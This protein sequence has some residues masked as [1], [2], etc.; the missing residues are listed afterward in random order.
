MLLKAINILKINFNSN[1]KDLL[2]YLS[3]SASGDRYEVGWEV[4]QHFPKSIKKSNNEKYLFDNR[5]EIKLQ[6]LEC[7]VPEQN[8]E[9]S[10]VC[11]ISDFD[12]HS[13]RKRWGK[14]RQ[15]GCFYMYE[16]KMNILFVLL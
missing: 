2:V 1:R 13:F 14:I 7:G 6:L 5:N 3:P 16:K 4:S 12:Y 8:I 10:A 9:V 11:T 15:D